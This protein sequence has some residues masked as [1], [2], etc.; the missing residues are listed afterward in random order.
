MSV[1]NP[2]EINDAINNAAEKVENMLNKDFNTAVLASIKAINNCAK[3]PTINDI[4]NCIEG[5][6]D[7]NLRELTK[8]LFMVRI[9]PSL[10]FNDLDWDGLRKI[11]RNPYALASYVFEKFSTPQQPQLQLPQTM[12]PTATITI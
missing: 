11:L 4:M 8:K 3:T 9:A 7:S 12:T 5:I 2:Q 10:G 1:P 6:E